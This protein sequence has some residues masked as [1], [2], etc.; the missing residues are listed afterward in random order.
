MSLEKLLGSL[1]S[2]PFSIDAYQ[3]EYISLRPLPSV[4]DP[5]HQKDLLQCLQNSSITST[6]AE[7]EGPALAASGTES[8]ETYG[9]T[10]VNGQTVFFVIVDDAGASG[11]DCCGGIFMD[12]CYTLDDLVAFGVTEDQKE[13]ITSKYRA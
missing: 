2:K 13:R 8:Y 6:F 7:T 4:R 11:Y 3:A 10:E 9:R 1:E 5:V 12:Y